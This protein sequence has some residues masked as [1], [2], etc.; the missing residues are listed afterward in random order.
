MPRWLKVVFIA[1]AMF[2]RPGFS[3]AQ[4]GFHAE[5]LDIVRWYRIEGWALPGLQDAT[6]ITKVDYFV[7]NDHVVID[8][9]SRLWPE[10]ITAWSIKHGDHRNHYRVSFPDA[11][12]EEDG[13]RKKMVQ[14]TFVLVWLV[15][16]EMNGTPYAYSYTLWPSPNEHVFAACMSS[17][18]IT[19]DKGDGK[20]RLLTS[21]GGFPHGLTPP[22]LPAW[23]KKPKT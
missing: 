22:P 4:C 11:I 19:D 17:I 6:A 10:G 2:Y 14:S 8:G 23:L 20:F 15:R 21:S 18:E 3:S 1:L 13:I 12:F 16:W 9:R 5:R 7:N